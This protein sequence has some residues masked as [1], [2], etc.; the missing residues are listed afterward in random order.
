MNKAAT[1]EYWIRG[2]M[3]I[4]ILGCLLIG[5]WVLSLKITGDGAYLNPSGRHWET[6]DILVVV[7]CLAGVIAAIG[8]RCH[9]RWASWLEL[10]FLAVLLVALVESGSAPY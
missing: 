7:S 6:A 9:K 2:F 10:G 5:G 1:K 8:V 3:N 4:Q